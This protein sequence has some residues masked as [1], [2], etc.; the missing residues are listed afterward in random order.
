MFTEG[1]RIMREHLISLGQ[2]IRE[3]RKERQLTLQE[4]AAQ[5]G[6]TPGLL[7]K[8]ENFRSIPSLP[9]LV[10]IAAALQVDMAELFGGMSFREH[11]SWLLVRRGE[12]KT[13]EREESVGLRYEA[14]IETPVEAAGLQA[15]VVTIDP[16]V[17]R[18]FVSS[19]ADELLFVLSGS[20]RYRLGEEE[21]EVDE[22]DLLFFDGAIAHRPFNPGKVPAVVF[23]CYLLRRGDRS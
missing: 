16:G 14:L 4:F 3:L 10:R 22:G 2:K 9:V 13:V 8:I 19:E 1:G 15:M 20:V 6:L 11:P 5:T 18:G 12:R 23:V 21:V 7:S 17:E